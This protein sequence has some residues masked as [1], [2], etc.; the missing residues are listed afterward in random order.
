MVPDYSQCHPQEGQIAPAMVSENVDDIAKKI[1][2]ALESMDGLDHKRL[3]KYLAST[4]FSTRSS[5]ERISFLEKLRALLGINDF[6]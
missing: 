6:Q 4:E 2:N 1:M 3:L 5:Q